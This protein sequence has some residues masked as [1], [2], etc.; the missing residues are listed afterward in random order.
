MRR[1][2]GVAHIQ[3][4]QQT[5]QQMA[6]LGAQ[7][8]AQRVEQ[9]ADQLE[10]LEH[11]LRQLADKHK[12]EIKEDPLVRA[13][14]RQ[15]ADSLGVDLI[16]SK[17][18]VFAGV[19]GL[20]DFYYSLAAKVV[21]CCSVERKFSGSFVPL[22]RILAAVQK[23]YDVNCASNKKPIRITQEDIYTALK[24]LGCLGAGYNIVELAN[25]K[26]VQTTPDGAVG[27]DEVCVLNLALATQRTQLDAERKKLSPAPSKTAGT[28]NTERSAVP[29]RS[30][31][32]VAY[33]LGT[34]PHEQDGEGASLALS[35]AA[36]LVS[37]TQSQIMEALLWPAHRV[38]TILERM[39]QS[40]AVWLDVP[41]GVSGARSQPTSDGKEVWKKKLSAKTA[42]TA[43]HAVY[44]FISLTSF[45]S[46][47]SG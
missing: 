33:I 8:T 2:I 7:I 14:F 5:Q 22:S 27:G 16:S 40:G 12:A 11:Q 15:L 30:Q 19:L 41:Q 4:Q 18:N 21:E 35:P 29:L 32:G 42:D 9:I 39:V 28:S 17:K 3:R 23:M 25:I 46:E 1:G 43:D 20:G 6:D 31:I 38:H 34:H 10:A 44:S 36:Q 13:R 26:Y 45:F 24:K 37:M 47:H